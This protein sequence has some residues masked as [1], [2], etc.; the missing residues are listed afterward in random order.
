MSFFFNKWLTDGK[1]GGF[2]M[3]NILAFVLLL[4]LT[5]GVVAD[6]YAETATRYVVNTAMEP[7]N[8]REGPGMMYDVFAHLKKGTA[9]DV[10]GYERGWAKIVHNF[11]GSQGRRVGYVDPDYL[12][13]AQSSQASRKSGSS[14]VV[15]TENAQ[16]FNVKSSMSGW[17]NVRKS[18]S[19]RAGVYGKLRPGDSVYVISQS[20]AWSEIVYKGKR[21]YVMTE[22]ITP[23]LEDNEA[24]TWYQVSVKSG[25]L[26]VRNGQGKKNKIIGRVSN[27]T[28]LFVLERYDAW[29]K[30]SYN[31][32]T[33]YV[34]NEFLVKVK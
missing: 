27:G 12:S 23:N 31:G 32:K 26:N 9:V 14:K 30:I 1:K 21:A 2:S 28:Y 16:L 25:R 7:L 17:L 6:V 29:S 4:C 20:G 11:G 13:G 10:V 33:A 8:V 19:K 22:F 34:M 24:G 18:Q 15:S 3:K 5:F